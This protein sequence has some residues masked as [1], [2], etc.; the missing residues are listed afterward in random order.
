MLIWTII[1]KNIYHMHR[2]ELNSIP[3]S[4]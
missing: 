1:D 2:S 3:Y 4:I